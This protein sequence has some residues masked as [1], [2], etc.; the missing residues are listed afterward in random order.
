M[1]L[2]YFQ[3]DE[4]VVDSVVKALYMDSLS[5]SHPI[6]VPVDDPAEIN[7][8]FDAISYNKVRAISF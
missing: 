3:M 1:P 8:I 2:L 5:N 4:F 6:S 7:E